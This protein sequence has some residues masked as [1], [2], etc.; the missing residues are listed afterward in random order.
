MADQLCT[1]EDLAS[2]LQSDLDASTANLWVD[3]C[4]AVVQQA[5]GGQRI[6]QVTGQTF[7]LVGTARQWLD[8]PQIPVTAIGTVTLDGTTITAGTAG[9]AVTT[10]RRVGNK[11][12]RGAGWQTY[13]G[14]PSEVVIGGVT[15]G[16]A[17]ASQ[18]LQLAR[19]AVIGLARM[20]Y[21]NASGV[22]SEKIDD[23]AVVYEKVSA[24]MESS[25]HLR[26][27]LS[28]AY[29]RRSGLVALGS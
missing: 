17:A 21:T 19:G 1:P 26:A 22:T 9:S 3:V 14:E 24:A 29:G 6:L 28:K 7:T 12:W 13:W 4:T 18:N 5:A 27:A 25:P 8:M 23:Y 2:A 11:L 15:H 16:Y 10:Y 20:A